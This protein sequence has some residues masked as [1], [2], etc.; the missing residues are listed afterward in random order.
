M[1]AVTTNDDALITW[2]Q[3]RTAKNMPP[4]NEIATA[5]PAIRFAFYGRISTSE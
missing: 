2:T 5:V 4:N 1:S 3:H